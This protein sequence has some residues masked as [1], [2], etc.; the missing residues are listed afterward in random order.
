[1]QMMEPTALPGLVLE[2]TEKCWFCDQK[3]KK[4][5]KNKE[6]EDPASPTGKR[7]SRENSEHN[8]SSALGKALK[9]RPTWTIDH[10][11]QIDRKVQMED[12]IKQGEKTNIVPAAHHLIPGGASLN[13]AGSLHKYMV[14]KGKN[15]KP[16]F[17]GPIGYDVNCRQ[18]GVWLPGNYAVRRGTEFKKSWGKFRDP[19]KSAYA[20]AAMKKAGNLQLHDAHPKYNDNVREILVFVGKKLEETWTDRKKCPV[21]KDDL[22]DQGDPP[23]GLVGR[24]H[25]LSGE[26]K[27]ALIFPRKNTKA[28]TSG[29]ITSSRVNDVYT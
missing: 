24:L 10:K 25:R 17:A 27:K 15:V 29:Y 13:K 9:K 11:V 28:I 14:W 1:M 21:C 4:P 3:P 2:K 16:P 7:A 23:Y 5:K 12:P 6:K 19:F 26:L 22:K 18:N 8:D 20:Q